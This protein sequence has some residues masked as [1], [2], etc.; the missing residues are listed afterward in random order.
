MTVMGRFSYLWIL[1]SV[2]LALSVVAFDAHERDKDITKA[3]SRALYTGVRAGCERDNA[4]GQR[5]EDCRQIAHKLVEDY[6]RDKP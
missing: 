2:G 4:A 3:T 1:F 5:K 6:L